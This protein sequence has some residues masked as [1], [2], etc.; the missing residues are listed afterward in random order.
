MPLD[1]RIDI[2]LQKTGNRKLTYRRIN[3]IRG[4]SMFMS[5][6][7]FS[8]SWGRNLLVASYIL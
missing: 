5:S 4:G 6:Q 7:T 2:K 8:G 3:F 1:L